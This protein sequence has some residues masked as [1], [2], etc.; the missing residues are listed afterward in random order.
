MADKII[1]WAMTC[2][3]D[4]SGYGNASVLLVTFCITEKMGKSG[5]NNVISYFFK[6]SLCI[7]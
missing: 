4:V 5:N 2:G 3:S 1:V 6:L 7:M